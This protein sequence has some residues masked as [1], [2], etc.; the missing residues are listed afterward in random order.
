MP[1]QIEANNNKSNN[2][3]N[4]L[5]ENKQ[6][7]EKSAILPVLTIQTISF[8]PTSS[9]SYFFISIGFFIHGC[10][11]TGWCQ[12]GSTFI[13]SA[14]LFIG[15]CQ[16]IL[17]MF[18]FYQKH[19]ILCLQNIVFGIWFISF[20]L[21]NFEINGVKRPGN[22]YSYLQGVTDLIMLFFVGVISLLIKGRGILFILDYFLLLISF[23]FLSLD[24]Y[25]EDFTI[26][27]TISGYCFFL[28]FLL[29]WFT[30]LGLIINDVFNKKIIRFV[31]PRIE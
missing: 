26:I 11:A 23:A 22:V 25:A 21:N 7:L 8:F 12:Y 30:G 9:Y 31:E 19:N 5:K 28:N 16:Y 4:E 27:V 10:Q 14:F 15:I 3:N 24:G 18:D 20:F 2:N 17:G 29:F 6:N 1:K 13:N